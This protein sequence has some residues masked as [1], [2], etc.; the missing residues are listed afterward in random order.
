MRILAHI[1]ANT[2]R[3]VYAVVDDHADELRRCGGVVCAVA[4]N[5]DVMSAE[6]SANMR[7]T[8][9]SLPRRRSAKP[10]LRRLAPPKS[11][12]PLKRCRKRRRAPAA[13]RHENRARPY[14]SSPPRCGRGSAPRS[15]SWE[16]DRP[17]C[18]SLHRAA[19]RVAPRS[20]VPRRV[21]RSR[22]P[23]AR[24]CDRDFALVPRGKRPPA[25][26]VAEKPFRQVSK[27]PVTGR[28]KLS[29]NG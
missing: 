20:A 21:G 5:H 7:R 29:G 3:H 14:R 25:R 2:N 26:D 22:N 12:R 13:A 11:C 24:S 27:A 9:L 28:S 15:R 16:K 23:A 18:R 4:V 10:P 1:G 19:A 8:K 17:R 6:I